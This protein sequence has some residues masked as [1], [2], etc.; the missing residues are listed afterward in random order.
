MHNQLAALTV[1]AGQRP[2]ALAVPRAAVA[3][4]GTASFVFVRRSDGVFDRR[5]VE[6]GHIKA[7][8]DSNV[9]KLIVQVV[10]RQEQRS[11]LK[12]VH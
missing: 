6:T 5:A 2:P 1:V 11:R 7:N 3:A 4:E 8:G 10:E 9:I 12:K